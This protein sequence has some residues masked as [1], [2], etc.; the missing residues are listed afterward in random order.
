[1][2]SYNQAADWRPFRS[3][4]AALP[5]YTSRHEVSDTALVAQR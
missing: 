2:K 1:M 5:A 4:I 3:G